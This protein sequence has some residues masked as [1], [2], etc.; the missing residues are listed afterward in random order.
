VSR[1]GRHRTASTRAATGVESGAPGRGVHALDAQPPLPGERCRFRERAGIG[2]SF[3]RFS[4][5]IVAGTLL[6]NVQSGAQH[7]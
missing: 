3:N 2:E 5:P 7:K 4:P 1:F 6:D